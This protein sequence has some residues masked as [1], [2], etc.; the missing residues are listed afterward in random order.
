MTSHDDVELLGIG[1][2]ESRVVQKHLADLVVARRDDDLAETRIARQRA[3]H[4]QAQRHQGAY[5]QVSNSALKAPNWP[6][7]ILNGCRAHSDAR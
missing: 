6:Q 3:Q 2:M 5:Q 4:A 1:H 7:R